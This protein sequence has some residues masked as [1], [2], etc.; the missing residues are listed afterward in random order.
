MAQLTGRH[1]RTYGLADLILFV[2]LGLVFISKG[3]PARGLSDGLVVTLAVAVMG[4]SATLG[5]WFV[6]F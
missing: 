2:V 5:L 6:L 4:A 1:W 3:I